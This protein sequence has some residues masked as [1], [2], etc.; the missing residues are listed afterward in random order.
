MGTCNVDSPHCV[1]QPT[2][3][4][5]AVRGH[6]FCTGRLST[7]DRPLWGIVGDREGSLPAV[8]NS[9]TS[10]AAMGRK[11]PLDI[12]SAQCPLSGVKQ[13]SKTLEMLDSD[14]RFRPNAAIRGWQNWVRTCRSQILYADTNAPGKYLRTKFPK[15]NIPK[16]DTTTHFCTIGLGDIVPTK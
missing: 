2:R 16:T 4:G 3:I 11:R 10:T 13:T 12:L 5:V 9:T 8:Q 15:M 1:R 7:S 6:L 14:F